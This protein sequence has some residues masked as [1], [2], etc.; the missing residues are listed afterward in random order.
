ML[1]V[2]DALRAL[3]EIIAKIVHKDTQEFNAL[4]AF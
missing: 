4:I 3:L 2:L 1:H